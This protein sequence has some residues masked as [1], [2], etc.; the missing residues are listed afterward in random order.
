[1]IHFSPTEIV[2]IVKHDDFFHPREG[3]VFWHLNEDV[4]EWLKV[5]VGLRAP[6]SCEHDNEWRS[7]IWSI[8]KEVRHAFFF[9]SRKKALLFAARWL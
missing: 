3:E 8:D 4:A 9:K 2:V 7:R 5:N 1:M 6:I